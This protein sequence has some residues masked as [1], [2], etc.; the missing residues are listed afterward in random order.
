M[1]DPAIGTFSTVTVDYETAWGTVKGS[2]AG[3]LIPVNSCTITPA[4]SLISNPTLRGDFNSGDPALGPISASG[5]LVKVAE[6]LSMPWFTKLLTGNLTSSVGPTNFIHSSIIS[7]TMP[8][9]AAIDT[10]FLIGSTPKYSLATGVRINRLSIPVEPTGFL[11][12]SF[13]LMAKTVVPGNAAAYSAT[14]TD[15]TS[16]TGS[17]PIDQLQLAS[18]EVKIGGSAV[19]YISKGSISIDANLNGNDYRVG[20]SGARGSLVPGKHKVSGSLDLALDSAAVLTLIT[21]GGATSLSFKWAAEAN[22]YITVFIPR[23][24]LQKTGPALSSDGAVMVT[25]QFEAS[26][27]SSTTSMLQITTANQT[28]GGVY[29]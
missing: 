17:S 5:S 20:A 18:A 12:T 21:A 3:F 2:P 24:F 28:A 14:A 26:Y 25:V 23:V 4:Q 11:T 16:A 22:N 15:W 6:G 10:K 27:D 29:V 13:D 19:G 8:L 1:S 7:N 9:S